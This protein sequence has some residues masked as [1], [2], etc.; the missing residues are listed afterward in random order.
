MEHPTHEEP[1]TD[2]TGHAEAVEVVF[3]P[4]R[5]PF[6]LLLAFGL[7]GAYRKSSCRPVPDY[8]RPTS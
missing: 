3:D 2:R 4:S 8:A 1:Y 6:D 5:L 7:F